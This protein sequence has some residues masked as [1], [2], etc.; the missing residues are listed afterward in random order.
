MQ[1]L[2]CGKRSYARHVPHI[3]TANGPSRDNQLSDRCI[4]KPPGSTSLR[5]LFLLLLLLLLL[6]LSASPGLAR[7]MVLLGL[8][9]GSPMH[10]ES[11]L[12]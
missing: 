1:K 8:G 12:S 11:V 6:F 7:V 5:L 4:R 3:R 2:Y 10:L 9:Q